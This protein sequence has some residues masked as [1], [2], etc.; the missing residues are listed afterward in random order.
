VEVGSGNFTTTSARIIASVGLAVNALLIEDSVDAFKIIRR[1][2]VGIFFI[3]AV[4]AQCMFAL[5]L[6]KLVKQN[7]L[8][9]LRNISNFKIALCAGQLML[10]IFSLV[11]SPFLSIKTNIENIGEWD[12]VLLMLIFFVC[13]GISWK[14]TKF[15]RVATNTLLPH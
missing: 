8:H 10:A 15:R 4:L 14:Q 1:V 9:H 7:N 3:G 11:I 12:I 2:F 13:T 6:K 5:E